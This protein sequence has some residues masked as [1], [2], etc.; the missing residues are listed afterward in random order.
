MNGELAATLSWRTHEII[1]DADP[2]NKGNGRGDPTD[3]DW[4]IFTG[5]F[6]SYNFFGTHYLETRRE[7]VKVKCTFFK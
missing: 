7:K 6:F 1:P 5:V 4:Y 2:P 3:L